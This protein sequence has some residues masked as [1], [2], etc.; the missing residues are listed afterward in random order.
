VH[1]HT[2]NNCNNTLTGTFRL[3]HARLKEPLLLLLLLLL[4]LTSLLLV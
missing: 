2:R 1:T 4:P 3:C